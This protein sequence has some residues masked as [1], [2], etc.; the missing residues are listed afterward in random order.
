MLRES[1]PGRHAV[2]R[3]HGYRMRT[4]RAEEGVH[5]AQ[6]S[7]SRLAGARAVPSRLIGMRVC[8]AGKGA[9]PG[10]PPPQYPDAKQE[11]EGTAVTNG[12]GLYRRHGVRV[13]DTGSYGVTRTTI[14]VS[15]ALR[16]SIAD[17]RGERQRERRLP[18]PSCR[19]GVHDTRAWP[20]LPLLFARVQS[21]HVRSTHGGGRGA[22]GY[23]RGSHRAPVSGAPPPPP[24]PLRSPRPAAP[25]ACGV[26]G[27][28]K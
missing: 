28:R 17:A 9:Q 15:S 4:E 21:L 12:G 10:A 13:S 1:R 5:H 18:N 19:R 22:R 14:D 11:A 25:S 8:H 27:V 26:F 24:L 7:I 2:A 16:T 6:P 20:R 3:A 23:P